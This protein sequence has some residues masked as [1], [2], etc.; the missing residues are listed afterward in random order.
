MQSVIHLILVLNEWFH[1][2]TEHEKKNTEMIDYT[3]E[4]F[5]GIL[6]EDNKQHNLDSTQLLPG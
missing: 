3:N 2:F 4:S 1:F 5:I 6:T